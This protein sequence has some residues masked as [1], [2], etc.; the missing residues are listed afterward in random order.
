MGLALG[1]VNPSRGGCRTHGMTT[2]DTPLNSPRT[3]RPRR[4]LI[5]SAFLLLAL[6]G[7]FVAINGCATTHPRR[8]PTGERFPT[9]TGADLNEDSVTLPDAF[10]GTPVLLLVGYQQ[11]TQFDLDRWLLGLTQ[12][13]GLPGVEIRE[14]PT[15]PGMVPRMFSGMIDSGMRS[16]IPDEDWGA[17]ITVYS[18][19]DAIAKFTG[20]DPGLPGRILL[21]DGDGTVVFFHD[22][23]YSV[24]ALTRL[25]DVAAGLRNDGAMTAADRS[26]DSPSS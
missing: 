6:A 7:V 26:G 24:G 11:N 12:A 14:L 17:V 16:G 5:G 18:D 19:G 8:N 4:R 9:V 2:P 13:G 3:K 10:A 20:N 22:E 21:L 15:I 25:M 1:G 23:G